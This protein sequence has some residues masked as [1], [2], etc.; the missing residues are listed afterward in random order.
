MCSE[1]PYEFIIQ[2][3]SMK[4]NPGEHLEEFNR[5]YREMDRI[6]HELA[7]NAGMSDSAFFILYAIVEM[8]NGYLQKD[9][10][11]RYS[12]SRQTVNSSVQNLKAKGYIEME[13]GNGRDRHIYLTPAGQQ[14][15]EKNIYPV[16]KME[17][18]AFQE[19]S[20]QESRELLK[21]TR[22]YVRIFQDKTEHMR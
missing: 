7:V 5:L 10:A 4:F 3:E 17:K 16:M 2:G 13:P 9:I 19:M 11:E 14:V 22:K 1:F 6:Y 12:I 15:A 20:E 21:L 18:A 8:G